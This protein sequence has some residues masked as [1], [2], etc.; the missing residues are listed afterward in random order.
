MHIIDE[1]TEGV[2]IILG[3]AVG[4]TMGWIGHLMGTLL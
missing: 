1:I 4:A 3:L 2:A